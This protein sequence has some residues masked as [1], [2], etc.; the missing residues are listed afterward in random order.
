MMQHVDI[1]VRPS[2]RSPSRSSHQHGVHFGLRIE[3]GYQGRKTL[4]YQWS[5]IRAVVQNNILVAHV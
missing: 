1:T 5:L 3:I 2:V 4:V